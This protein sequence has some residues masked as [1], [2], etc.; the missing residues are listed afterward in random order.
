[1]KLLPRKKYWVYEV[2][3]FMG[4][5][6][7]PQKSCWTKTGAKIYQKYLQEKMHTLG[8]ALGYHILKSNKGESFETAHRRINSGKRVRWIYKEEDR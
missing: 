6:V 4:M 1:M 7:T 5:E 3:T 2:D 8:F